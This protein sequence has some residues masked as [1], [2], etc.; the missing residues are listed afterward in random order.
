MPAVSLVVCLRE[1]RSLLKRLI[2]RS[3]DCYDDLVVVHDGPDVENIKELVCGAGG[4]F[5]ERSSMRRQ[6]PHWPYAWSQAT[7]DWILR[8]DADE[9]PSDELKRWLSS[10]RAAPEPDAQIA[11]YTCHWPAW[12]GRR[13]ICERW[14][15]GRLFLFRKTSV[16]YFGMP[17][18]S[19]I[20]EGIV[21]TVNASLRHEPPNRKSHGVRNVILRKQTYRWRSQIA[22]SLLGKPTDLACWRWDN[23]AW[24]EHWERVRSR[25]FSTA[26]LSFTLWLFRTLR[27]QWRAERRLF[28][29]AA[30]GGPLNHALL[31][32]SYWRAKKLQVKGGATANVTNLRSIK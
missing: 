21:E 28:L 8:L 23:E 12:D 1:Q 9:Y 3:R 17:E 31:C 18:Q 16:R 15:S 29:T 19:P 13:A 20:T 5:F 7:S 22:Q 2:V 24:P 10:F 11:G 25:P 14:P 27:D 30:V 6:E 26:V 4:R 32:L